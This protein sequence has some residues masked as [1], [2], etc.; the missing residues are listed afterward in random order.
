MSGYRHS[1]RIACVQLEDADR[2][3]LTSAI[4]TAASVMDTEFVWT[5]PDAADI[6]I[7]DVARTAPEQADS[8]ADSAVV[9]RYSTRRSELASDVS[10]PINIRHLI[11]VLDNAV[12]QAASRAEAL[13]PA[14]QAGVRHYRGAVVAQDTP[15]AARAPERSEAKAAPRQ[16]VVMYRGAPVRG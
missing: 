1:F 14:P 12:R 5:E 15:P 7:V 16:T 13:V 8:A 6:C 11:A 10:R 2:I 9:I 4:N 3:P